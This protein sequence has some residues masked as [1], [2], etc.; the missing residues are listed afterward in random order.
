MSKRLVYIT[1]PIILIVGI[2]F[3]GPEPDEPKW[4]MDMPVV[5]AQPADLEKYVALQESKHKLKTDNEARI[6][7]ADSSKGQTEYSVVYL[8]GFSASQ[9]EGDPVHEQFAKTFGCNLYLARMADHGVDTTAQLL[10]FTPD[11]WWQ[12]SKEA[13]A[14]GKRLG[15]KVIIMS[16]STGG[17]MALILA[18][19]FPQ[20][21]F[22]L[23]NMSPNIAINDPLAWVANDPWG[24]QLARLVK[25]GEYLTGTLKPGVDSTLYN[26]YWNRRYRLEAGCQLQEMLESKMN[27]STFQKVIQPSLTLYYFKNEKEQDPTVKVSA[28]LTM[29]E[30]LG[31][32]DSLKSAVAIPNAGGHVLGSHVTSGDID[33]VSREARKFAVEKLKMKPVNE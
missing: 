24:L 22:A 16:T 25:G 8:H 5:P 13:L 4:S 28:M 21:V 33:A 18:S 14:I 20:D 30:Q 11:R 15:K 12:S 32:P 6:I 17:T 3:M 27:K 31:T 10:Y 19:A 9:E 23:I 26:R 7:W 2:Y 1:F 29:N